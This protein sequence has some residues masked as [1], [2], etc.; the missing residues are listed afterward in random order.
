MEGRNN[1][2]SIQTFLENEKAGILPNSF[3]IGPKIKKTRGRKTL[4]ARKTTEQ[5][6]IINLCA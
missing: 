2:N 4:Q 3:I 1:T 5:V 6:S